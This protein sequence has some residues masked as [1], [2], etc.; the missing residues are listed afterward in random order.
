[1]ALFS[2]VRRKV[3]SF[4]SNLLTEAERLYHRGHYVAAAMLVRPFVERTIKARCPANWKPDRKGLGPVCSYLVTNGLL[5]Q[6][7][8]NLAHSIYSRA[9]NVCH[10]GVVDRESARRLLSDARRLACLEILIHE[11]GASL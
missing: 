6:L 8:A 3:E 10:R 9:S 1:M 5:E 7:T 4:P 11:G 2:L